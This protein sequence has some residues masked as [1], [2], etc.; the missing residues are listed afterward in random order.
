MSEIYFWVRYKVI[1]CTCNCTAISPHKNTSIVYTS[2]CHFH[3]KTPGVQELEVG[4]GARKLKI[5]VILSAVWRAW[6]NEHTTP[7]Y[8][9]TS[10]METF[11][12]PWLGC[13]DP[14]QF[15]HK[16]ESHCLEDREGRVR[17]KSQYSLINLF[18]HTSFLIGS[19][20]YMPWV[21]G[22]LGLNSSCI[23]PLLSPFLNPG[24]DQ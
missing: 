24:N 7:L 18:S 22:L 4:H 6:F 21:H 3:Y 23:T 5:D 15:W 9:Y 2:F 8:R 16:R 19:Q 1:L 11:F 17:V 10:L 13:F 14:T 12:I 20:H